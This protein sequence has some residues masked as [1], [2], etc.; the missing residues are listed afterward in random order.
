MKR[1]VSE[2]RGRAILGILRAGWMGSGAEI[3]QVARRSDS[4]RRREGRVKSKV[5]VQGSP[6]GPAGEVGRQVGERAAAAA[7]RQV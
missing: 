2:K 4:C 1:V 7:N 5:R 3:V 6:V